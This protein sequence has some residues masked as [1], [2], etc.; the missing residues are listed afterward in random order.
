[1]LRRLLQRV[2]ELLSRRRAADEEL[3][4]ELEEALLSAD[5]SYALALELIDRLRKAAREQRLRDA[6]DVKKLLQRMIRQ[7]LEPLAKPLG[8]GQQSPT[9]YVMLG[10]NGVG[11]TTT[12]AKL[13]YR[14][15]RQGLKPLLVA[16]DTFRAAAIEQLAEWAQRVGCDIVRQQR[17]ADAGAV[18]FDALAAAQARGHHLVIIDT[19]GRLHTKRHLMEELRKIVRIAERQLGRPPDERLLVLDATTGQNALAQAREFHEAVGVTGLILTKLDGTAKGGIVLTIAHEL[20]LP[21]RALGL[22]ENMEA[23][24]DFSAADFAAALFD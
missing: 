15:K 14:F 17:G 3:L 7:L 21:I 19:A 13:A 2:S 24:E 9:V 4:E 1:M 16:A 6:E 11:K 5:V 12:I 22:G 8:L 20:G 18:V 10:V 23:L